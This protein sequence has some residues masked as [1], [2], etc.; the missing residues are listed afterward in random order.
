MQRLILFAILICTSSFATEPAKVC[1][2]QPNGSEAK[3]WKIQNPL[4]HRIE[5]TAAGKQIQVLA[6]ILNSD[7]EKHAKSEARE[8]SCTYIVLTTIEKGYQSAVGTFNPSPTGSQSLSPTGAIAQAAI[9]PTVKCKVITPE[10]RKVAT[11]IT[12]MSLR[13]NPTPADFEEAGRKMLETL[14]SQI[15]DAL[16]K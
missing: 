10:G 7:D 14:A 13:E 4:A 8:K 6:P 9:A 1:V 11:S 12:S 3:N 15:V 2:A 5:T 16:P